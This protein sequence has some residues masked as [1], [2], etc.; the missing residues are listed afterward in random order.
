MALRASATQRLR[1]CASIRLSTTATTAIATVATVEV[2]RAAMS[3]H[4]CSA[5]LSALIGAP[6]ESVERTNQP[7][8]ANGTTTLRMGTTATQTV[9]VETVARV[10]TTRGPTTLEAMARH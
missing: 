4:T 9:T 8:R 5:T 2:A 6:N 10:S 3:F 7:T 1:R